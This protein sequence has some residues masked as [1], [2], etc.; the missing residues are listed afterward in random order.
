MKS[1]SVCGM[2]RGWVTLHGYVSGRV[3]GVFFRVETRRRAL[4]LGLRGWVRNVPDGR[5]EVLISGAGAAVDAMRQWLAVGPPLAMV[6]AL[7]LEAVETV[8]Q[9]GFFI[10]Y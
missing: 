10:H 4:Q 6:E 8:P 2:D 1:G 5:V 3:Q 7:E 9:E